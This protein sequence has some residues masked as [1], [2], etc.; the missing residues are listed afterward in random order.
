MSRCPACLS[1][2]SFF[3]SSHS[4]RSEAGV[5]EAKVR[6]PRVYTRSG[7]SEKVTI[8]AEGVYFLATPMDVLRW[9]FSSTS[10]R[11]PSSSLATLPG[12]GRSSGS[13]P[14]T[15]SSRSATTRSC[16]SPRESGRLRPSEAAC[17]KRDNMASTVRRRPSGVVRPAIG[18]TC[19]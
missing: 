5:A 18:V 11:R 6:N 1:L 14:A 17:A 4:G 2:L 19:N 9:R 15:S 7:N 8:A 10:L 3:V 12:T 16:P 13:P